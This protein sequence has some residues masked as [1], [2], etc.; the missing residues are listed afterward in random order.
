[1]IIH[2]KPFYCSLEIRSDIESFEKVNT[3][4][5]IKSILSEW[6]E[7]LMFLFSV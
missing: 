3:K 5:I 1:M 7:A 4:S 2:R 6:F